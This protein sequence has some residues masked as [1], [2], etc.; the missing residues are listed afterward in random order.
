MFSQ[1]LS[2][3]PTGQASDKARPFHPRIENQQP[4]G[5][6]ASPQVRFPPARILIYLLAAMAH[7]AL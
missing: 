6:V 2:V 4:G 5:I 1:R 7:D 3:V